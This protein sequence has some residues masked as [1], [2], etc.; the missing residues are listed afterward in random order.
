VRVY[1][2]HRD[3]IF[4]L[5][6]GDRVRFV[7]ARGEVPSSPD[8]VELLQG[9]G[10]PLLRVLE[11]GLLTLPLDRGRFRAGRYGLAR[12]GPMDARAFEAATRMMGGAATALEL[13]LVGPLLEALEEVTVALA[14]IGPGYDGSWA[15]TVTLRKGE[16]LDLRRPGPGARSYLTLPGG[17]ALERFMGSASPD[18][19]GRIGRPLVAGDE[20]LAQLARESGGAVLQTPA[21]LPPPARKP[22]PVAPW[23]WGAAFALF[24]LERWRERRVG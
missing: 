14:G 3:P 11:P 15:R 10:L 2:P 7:P 12:S 5:Q 22:V 23:L 20:K 9:E 21:D 24:L 17:V 8:A 1:D 4:W 19:K 13:N 18:L 6:A 16:T